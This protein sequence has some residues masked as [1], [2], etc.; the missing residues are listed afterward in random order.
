MPN[1]G[2]RH[3]PFRELEQIL[4][5]ST[6][7]ALQRTHSNADTKGLGK[8]FTVWSDSAGV[9]TANTTDLKVQFFENDREIASRTVQGVLNTTT[10]V[11][12]LTSTT[13]TG[14]ETVIDYDG[15]VTNNTGDSVRGDVTHVRSQKTASAAFSAMDMSGSG[16]A[17]GTI[18]VGG[19]GGDFPPG[20]GGG[21][22]K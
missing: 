19:G 5:K 1:V 21:G 3:F 20:G 22:M 18:T 16:A 2:S 17:P 15:T 6:V 4:P 7:A 8:S 12:T 10:G 13:T 11:W 14:E 9:W